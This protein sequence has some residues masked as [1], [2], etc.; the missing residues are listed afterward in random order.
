MKRDKSGNALYKH[1]DIKIILRED[2]KPHH[3]VLRAAPGQGYSQESI[4]KVIE[5]VVEQLE[6]KH[7]FW[8]FRLV[9]RGANAISFVFAG[10]KEISFGQNLAFMSD[11]GRD[12]TPK[13]HDSEHSGT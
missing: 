8:E 13:T 5:N 4:D 6:L 7:P 2:Q 10:T 12:M 9:E 3:Q 1:I 11:F